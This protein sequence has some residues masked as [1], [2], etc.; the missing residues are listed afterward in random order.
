[1]FL[2]LPPKSAFVGVKSYTKDGVTRYSVQASCN[3]TLVYLNCTKE[4]HDLV[5]SSM[6]LK[7]GDYSLTV[8]ARSFQ[9][10]TYFEISGVSPVGK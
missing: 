6:V 9:E 2:I 7:Q 5:N 4:V 8:T 10:R 1:M 3:N